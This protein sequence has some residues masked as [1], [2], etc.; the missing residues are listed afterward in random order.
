MFD[1]LYRNAFAVIASAAFAFPA[2]GASDLP[3][4][5]DILFEKPHIATV[6]AGTELVYK[7]V[8]KPSDEAMLGK[9]FSDDI[10]VK[11]ES[12]AGPG[13]KNVLLQIYTGERA[14]DP[15]RI[16]DMDGNPM[17]VVYLD[18][19]VAHFGDLAGGD[20]AYLKNMFKRTLGNGSK[21]EPVTI[22][23][24]GAPVAGYKVSITPYAN[25]P[26]RAKMRGYEGA[27]FTIAVSEKIPGYFAQMVS[28]YSNSGKDAPTLEETTTLEGVGEVR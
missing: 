10:T 28:M 27:T 3:S 17:L 7:F 26:A 22:T 16:T 19:A 21:I 2:F 18:N 20:R 12:D 6:A 15:H 9:G 13:K 11:V 24:K 25:D 5:P 14:R 23:Y 8:R 4:P 1:T